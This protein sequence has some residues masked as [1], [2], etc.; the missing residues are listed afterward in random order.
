MFGFLHCYMVIYSIIFGCLFLMKTQQTFNSSSNM[1]N[2]IFFTLDVNQIKNIPFDKY[3]KNF[4]FFV[5]GEEFKVNRIIADLLSPKIRQYHMVDESINSFSIEIDGIGDKKEIMNNF[6]KLLS[7]FD[8]SSKE[9]TQKELS[10]FIS[11]FDKL[12]NNQVLEMF[13]IN[14]EKLIGKTIFRIIEAKAKKLKNIN[15]SYF[16]NEIDFLATHFYIPS[17]LQTILEK[18]Q[19]DNELFCLYFIK[20]ILSNENLRIQNED[21][22][23]DF[24]MNIY[25]KLDKNKS[26]FEL[27]EFL[28]FSNLKVKKIQSFLEILNIDSLTNEL[29]LSLS[30]RLLLEVKKLEVNNERYHHNRKIYNYAGVGDELKGIFY[31]LTAEHG[32]NLEEKG[33]IGVTASSISSEQLPKYSLD[34]ESDHYYRSKNEPNSWIYYDFKEKEITLLHYSIRSL[35]LFGPFNNQPKNWVLEGSINLNNWDILDKQN[36]NMI[37]NG[38]GRIFSTKIA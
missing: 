7:F 14:Q 17:V 8:Y 5:N 26:A 1:G 12:E 34:F 19:L 20:L 32:G 36:N 18:I 2:N 21:S 9:I 27:F 13:P 33:V 29:W 3:E 11:L 22:L 28:E 16:Q 38:K 6:S 24:I 10:F 15:F 30:K 4:S 37:L 25:Q 35:Q 31:N 23:F